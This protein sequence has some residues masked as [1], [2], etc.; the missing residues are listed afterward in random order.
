MLYAL[1]MQIQPHYLYNTL[2]V[3]RMTAL[4]QDDY[5]TAELLENMAK[6]LRYVMGEQT[7]RVYL[8]DEIDSIREYFVLM[9]A[10]YEGWISLMVYLADEDGELLVPKMILQ[11][12]VE[13]AIRHGL[14]EK[15]GPGAV[16]VRANR[17]EDYL[18]IVVMD[19]GVGMDEERAAGM[20]A[21]LE[22]S[23]AGKGEPN[24]LVS[25]GTKNVYDRI[26][27]NCGAEYGFVI[28]SARGMGTIVTY[29]LP[30]WEEE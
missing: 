15:E 21:Y 2:D 5:R 10:R 16:A 18:E 6:Q 1:K 8:K 17:K 20:Q 9:R 30:I 12:V 24:E 29:R 27:L 11:P 14:R 23:H 22:H 26:K 3:I 28:Q 25:V 7:D 13:N 4:D 19:D